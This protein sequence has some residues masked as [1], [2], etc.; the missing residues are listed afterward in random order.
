MANKTIPLAT[1]TIHAEE[2]VFIQEAFDK[3]WIAPLGGVPG[4]CV[5]VTASTVV[6]V[7]L[8]R[9]LD[10]AKIKEKFI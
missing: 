10:G 9:L 7:A 1:P 6:Y 4:Y 5:Q 2:M 3:N 8:G